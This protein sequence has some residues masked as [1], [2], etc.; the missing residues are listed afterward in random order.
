MAVG[1][2]SP[3]TVALPSPIL[4][5]FPHFRQCIDAVPPGLTE[6]DVK[7]L[8]EQAVRTDGPQGNSVRFAPDISGNILVFAAE[9]SRD[10]FDNLIK[11][12]AGG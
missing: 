1:G 2:L 11:V 12:L 10:V 4:T 7:E 6:G 3:D 8:G 9:L 5:G